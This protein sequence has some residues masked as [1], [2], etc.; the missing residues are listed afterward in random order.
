M[1]IKYLMS[2]LV[3][4]LTLIASFFLHISLLLIGI[5]PLGYMFYL[6]IFGDD[7]DDLLDD[8]DDEDEDY[9]EYDEENDYLYHH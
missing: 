1:S 8:D 6:F 5:I 9:E 2:F 4:V 7:S 3:I